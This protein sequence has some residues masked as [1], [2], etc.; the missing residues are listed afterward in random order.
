MPRERKF[1]VKTQTIKV[2]IAARY[3]DTVFY[4]MFSGEKL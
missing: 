4:G 1:D 3:R 2:K